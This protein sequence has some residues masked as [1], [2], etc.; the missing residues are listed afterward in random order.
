MWSTNTRRA[1]GV[2]GLALGLTVLMSYPL[3]FRLA[4][5]GRV[6]TGDGFFNIWNVAWIAQAL[7][8][9]PLQVFDANI[10][11]PHRNTL[12]FAEANFGAG[13][14]AAPFWWLTG[15]PYL[16]YNVP[17]FL[18]Y[19]LSFLAMFGLVRSLTGQTWGALISAITFA[20]SPYAFARTAHISL[21]M[22]FVLPLAL[23]TFHRFVDRPTMGRA[24]WL[25]LGL[26]VAAPFCGYY[27]VFAGLTVGLGVLT[28]AALRGLWR[29]PTYWLTAMWAAMLSITLALP[30]FLPYVRLQEQTGFSRGLDE[31][32]EYAA[33]W[34][35][36]HT[37]AAW[38]HRWMIPEV[39]NDVLFPGFVVTTLGLAGLWLGLRGERPGG[40]R[41]PALRQATI[42]YTL[43]AVLAFWA[44]FGPQAWLYSVFYKI[45]PVFSLMHVPSRFGLLTI[46][47]LTVL[48]ANAVDALTR[49][50]RG[51]AVLLGLSLITLADLAVLPLAIPDA[52]PVNGVYR[53]LGR[54]P[55][56]AVAEMPFFYQRSD[57]P[58]HAYYMFNST[59]HWQPLINGYSDHIPT[60]FRRM[61]V[62]LSTFP[63][64]ASFELLR[65]RD[66]RYVVFH[67]DMY[68]RAN[69]RK[70]L[71]RLDAYQQYLRPLAED[72]D[73]RLYE[74]VGQPP[75]N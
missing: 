44:S 28:Y 37:S 53:W 43:L 3:A 31:A 49:G 70:L 15:N 13:A 58:R 24:T 8:S 38:A 51:R 67:L 57:F 50:A 23:W 47:A 42:F 34:A 48:L 65:Q 4:D 56:G 62:Q 64:R 60:D 36:Y 74:I 1:L 7:G 66:T 11:Y 17:S 2:I 10:Y 40:P 30:L 72:G 16:A 32:S 33:S 26:W 45:L 63:S 59:Y 71:E 12:A 20:F 46:L 39:W 55:R 27:A 61:V 14:I 35:D 22:T 75:L 68:D 9:D 19:A 5:V 6:N 54:L 18:A 29:Q 41:R 21:Q 52:L 73:V 69:R 25:G